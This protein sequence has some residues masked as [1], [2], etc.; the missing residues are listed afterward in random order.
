MA[1]SELEFCDLGSLAR[2]ISLLRTAFSRSET[3][4]CPTPWVYA[5]RRLV[6][7]GLVSIGGTGGSHQPFPRAAF[8]AKRNGLGSDEITQSSLFTLPL[9]SRI[10]L[11][12]CVGANVREG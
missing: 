11:L 4:V 6:W 2:R 8:L 7:L 3:S 1:R 10:V 12:L 5:S 9:S